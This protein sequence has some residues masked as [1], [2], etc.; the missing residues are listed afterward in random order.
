MLLHVFGHIEAHQG[1]FA[2]EEELRQTA[3]YFGLANT[4]GAEEQEASDRAAGRFESGAA[5]TNG[6]SESRDGFLLTDDALVQLYFDA[7]QFLLLVFLDR[8][9]RYARPAR[10]DL[11]DVFARDDAS[12]GVIQLQ[13]LAQLAQ[14]IFFFALF[15][16]IEPRFLK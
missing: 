6:A 10:N 3:S 12:R 15:F 4:G 8:G 11:F 14:V 7:Q 9:D 2:A 16:G 5:P 13:T 1:L